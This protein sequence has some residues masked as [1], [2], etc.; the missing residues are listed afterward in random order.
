GL[1]GASTFLGMMIDPMGGS[2]GGTASAPG[3]SLIEMADL[4][5]AR[6]PAA[7]VEAAWS[8]WTRAYG[9]AGRTASDA[10]LGAAGTASSSYGIAAGADKLVSP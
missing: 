1:A 2:R 4:G 3:S 7:Q 6:T 5:A 10:G 8:I 9:Q